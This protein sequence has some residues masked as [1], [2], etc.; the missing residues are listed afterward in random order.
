MPLSHFL[1]S[2]PLDFS[3]GILYPLSTTEDFNLFNME[4]VCKNKR[5]KTCPAVASAGPF[6]PGT[7]IKYVCKA[8]GCIYM[9]RCGM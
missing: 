1:F 6:T 7:L 2:S 5:C 3:L 4:V 8:V 9:I